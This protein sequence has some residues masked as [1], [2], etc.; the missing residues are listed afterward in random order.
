MTRDGGDRRVI[1]ELHIRG[2][3]VIDDTSLALAPGLTVVTGETGIFVADTLR[4]DLTLHRN[5]QFDIDWESFSTFRGVSEGD[6][7]TFA[8]PKQEPLKAEL[9][10]FFEAVRGGTRFGVPSLASGLAVV[11]IADA[12]MRSSDSGTVVRL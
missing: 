10:S 2:L 11:Q 8:F 4:G 6:T 5:G 9:L 1:E 12:I 3:G 7:T